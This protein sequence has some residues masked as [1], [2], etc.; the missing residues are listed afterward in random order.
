M[1]KFSYMR[2]FL[3]IERLVIGG[4]TCSNCELNVFEKLHLCRLPS[5]GQLS[6]YSRRRCVRLSYPRSSLKRCLVRHS[7]VYQVKLSLSTYR[8]LCFHSSMPPSVH[9]SMCNTRVYWCVSRTS[10]LT[11]TEKSVT[12]HSNLAEKGTLPRW[13]RFFY[14][15]KKKHATHSQV[16]TFRFILKCDKFAPAK[17]SAEMS[18]EMSNH[19]SGIV[20][21]Q[22]QIG[23]KH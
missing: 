5:G 14:N 16:Q 2:R 23:N 6:F 9:A 7:N 19:E 22:W 8:T 10:M 4:S 13:R 1:R 3:Y 21:A 20:R 17:A 18:P 12:L 11:Q 15:K